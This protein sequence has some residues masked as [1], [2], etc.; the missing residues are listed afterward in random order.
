MAGNAAGRRS[1]PPLAAV[2]NRNAGTLRT[3]THVG[4]ALRAIL[5]LAGTFVSFTEPAVAKKEQL[6]AEP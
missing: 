4:E 6:A 3:G 5:G 1:R 2:E